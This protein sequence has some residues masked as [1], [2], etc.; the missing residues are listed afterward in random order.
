M[1]IVYNEKKDELNELQ[2][3]GF[4]RNRNQAIKNELRQIPKGV[5]GSPQ[6][7]LRFYYNA[8]RRHDFFNTNRPKEDTLGVA[9]NLLK[10]DYPEFNPKFNLDFFVVNSELE[11]KNKPPEETRFY[12]ELQKKVELLQEKKK[13]RAIVLSLMR[14]G[15]TLTL[16]LS[17]GLLQFSFSLFLFCVFSGCILL[18]LSTFLEKNN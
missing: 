9:I 8:L 15:S 5:K 17:F 16:F 7:Y 12:L 1:V 3:Y 11:E 18:G 13:R 10:R 4:L 2:E 6:N 14:G